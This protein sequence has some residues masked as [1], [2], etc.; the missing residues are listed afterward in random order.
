MKRALVIAVLVA[1][2]GD[3]GGRP[4]IDGVGELAACITEWQNFGFTTCEVACNRV[5]EEAA[6]TFEEAA[7]AGASSATAGNTYRCQ[8]IYT[9]D[10][11]RGCCMPEDPEMSPPDDTL[12]WYECPAD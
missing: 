2:C 1:G 10:G 9:I 5:L 4:P 12:Y 3:D 7:C 11:R 8:G 6:S